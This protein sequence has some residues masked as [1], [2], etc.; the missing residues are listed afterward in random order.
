MGLLYRGSL[1]RS[2]R[3]VPTQTPQL[4]LPSSHV[5]HPPFPYSFNMKVIAVAGGTGH[6]GR[7]IVETLVQSPSFK[8]IVLGRKVNLPRLAILHVVL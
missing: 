5:S 4:Q 2:W 1:P 8:V 3:E 6:V 7:T